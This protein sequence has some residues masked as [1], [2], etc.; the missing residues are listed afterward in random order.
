MD[1]QK[2]KHPPKLPTQWN[3]SYISYWQPMQPQDHITS[4]YCWFDYA[5]NVCRID[6]LFNPWSE[7]K[8]GHRLWMSEIMYP[9]TNESFKSKIAYS[10]AQMDQQSSFQEQVLNDEVDPCHELIL[11]QDVLELC[12]AEFIGTCEVMGTEA[13]IWHFERPNN[14][15]PATYYFKAD[16]NQL[17]RM[18]TGDPQKMASVRDFPNFNTREIDPEIFQPTPLKQPE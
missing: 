11:M 10:R 15:G 8:T 14:K 13:D 5:N 7:E 12:N 18:V 16:T 6:G 3:S 2:Q 1:L 17:L 4:G 9:A